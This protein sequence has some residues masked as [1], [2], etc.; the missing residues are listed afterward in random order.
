MQR[1]KATFTRKRTI[2]DKSEVTVTRIPPQNARTRALKLAR[3]IH[4]EDRRVTSREA[5]E[6]L[7]TTTRTCA[8]AAQLA[9]KEG[10][11]DSTPGSGGGYGRGH[12]QPPAEAQEAAV[13]Q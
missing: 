11:L 8:R 5:R 4:A 13:A 1:V 7:G 6:Y 10:W 3:W 12:C 9:V 2:A